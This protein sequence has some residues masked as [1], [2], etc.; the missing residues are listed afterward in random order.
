MTCQQ[1]KLTISVGKFD[2]SKYRCAVHLLEYV[3]NRRSNSLRDLHLNM[4]YCIGGVCEAR[5]SIEHYAQWQARTIHDE[6]DL[7]CLG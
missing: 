5:A 1:Q 4:H 6:Y 3:S 7:K 2:H